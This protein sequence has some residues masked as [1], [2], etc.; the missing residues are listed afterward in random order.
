MT[1][2]VLTLIFDISLSIVSLGLCG[3]ALWLWLDLWRD[4]RELATIIT[5]YIFPVAG[6]LNCRAI[7]NALERPGIVVARIPALAIAGRDIIAGVP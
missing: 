3:A 5:Y 4:N 1:E 6:G 7:D 2:R